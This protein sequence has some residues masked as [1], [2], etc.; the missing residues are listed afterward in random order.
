[1]N[2]ILLTVLLSILGGVVILFG[3]ALMVKKFYIKVSPGEA[4]VNN[5]TGNQVTVSFTGGLVLPII[6]RAETMDISVKAIEID[7]RGKEG[8]TCKDNIRADIKVVFFVRVNPLEADVLKV[9]ESIGCIRASHQETLDDLFN[10]K[11]SEALKTVGYQMNFVDLYTERQ[12]FKDRIVEIIGKDLNGYKL[13]DV[14]IDFLEQTPVSSLDP[15]NTL[16]AEG[17]RAI[18]A[19]TTVKNMETNRLRNTEQKEITKQNVEAK[20][21]I[22]ALQRQQAEAEARQQREIAVVRA[23]EHAETERVAAEEHRRAKDA[24]IKAEEEIAVQNE[25]KDRQIQVAQKNR[26][27]VVGIETERVAK[28][29]ALEAIAR[30]REVELL[31]IE[32]E[33]LIEIQKKDIADVVRTRVAVERTLAE[34]EERI[35]D[36]RV[37]SEAKRQRDV[38]LIA[39]ET[40]AQEKLV[41]DIKE[42]EAA[43]KASVH[44][45]KQRLTTADADLEAADREARAKIRK[46]EG[47]QAEAAATGLAEVKV[48]EADAV[49]LE[50]R[51]MVEA[52]LVKE[53]LFAAAEGEKARG[54][55]AAQ[56]AEAQAEA[57]KKQGFVEA[58]VVKTKL[59]AQAAGEEQMG[60]ARARG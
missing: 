1:M 2:P 37:G 50:K 23:K 36:V 27:R 32:K 5:K 12:Q 51:G 40:S 49:A 8:L 11:F 4:L 35:K 20:E 15:E 28:D 17:I 44:W 18:T 30:E 52:R 33:K 34:E 56:V 46:A 21:T 7:R 9:A 48:R 60:L 31:R 57:N 14:A 43:E 6:H 10:A 22:L 41:K 55:T 58:D 19:I 54:F 42:A 13:E 25:N 29:R 47:T 3:A 16:D 53:K 24:M 45:A 59:E 39:A 26:E 38:K